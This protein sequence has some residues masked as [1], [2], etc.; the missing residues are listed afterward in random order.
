LDVLRLQYLFGVAE[1]CTTLFIAR[2]FIFFRNSY[3]LAKFTEFATFHPLHEKNQQKFLTC[4]RGA[5][6]VDKLLLFFFTDSVFCC[7]ERSFES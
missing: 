6:K 4:L 2:F 3:G 1:I 5:K 7:F